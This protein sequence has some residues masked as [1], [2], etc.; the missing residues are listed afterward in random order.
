[1][2]GVL[3]DVARVLHRQRGQQ[4]DDVVQGHACRPFGV[5]DPAEHLHSHPGHL[6]DHVEPAAVLGQ[7]VDELVPAEVRARLDVDH[8]GAEFNHPLTD[9]GEEEAAETA[10]AAA[11]AA[12]P[13]VVR[14]LPG[15]APFSRWRVHGDPVGPVVGILGHGPRGVDGHV[16][17]DPVP[18]GQYLE[19]GEERV[20]V[21]DGEV[22]EHALGQVGGVHIH[23]RVVPEEQHLVHLLRREL[24]LVGPPRVVPS[25]LPEV[26]LHVS[27]LP[28]RGRV[29]Q[30][31]R[32]VQV[33]GHLEGQ[34]LVHCHP[35]GRLLVVLPGAGGLPSLD[36]DAAAAA[37]TAA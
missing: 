36:G 26:D 30:A 15:L 29:S 27:R 35:P 9:L 19:R 28:G 11:G 17:V 6:D 1:M 32:L 13:L 21:V 37:A 14:L 25:N 24:V 2:F 34:A 31:L 16:R 3:R 8:V 5:G 22:R 10:A 33:R 18:H 23:H 4:P 20:R 7:G 12:G